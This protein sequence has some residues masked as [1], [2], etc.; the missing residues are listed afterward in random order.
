MKQKM[1]L[2][3]LFFRRRWMV[4]TRMLLGLTLVCP[5]SFLFFSFPRPHGKLNG[6]K[7]AFKMVSIGLVEPR[8]EQS[9]AA[10]DTKEGSGFSS[11]LMDLWRPSPPGDRI[12]LLHSQVPATQTHRSMMNMNFGW[13]G[14]RKAESSYSHYIPCGVIQRIYNRGHF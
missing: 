8:P 6:F 5:G 3:A 12:S 7:Q 11:A 1:S 2:S 10:A 13:L 4:H 9:Y 14:W